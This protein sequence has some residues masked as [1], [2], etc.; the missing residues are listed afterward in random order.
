MPRS[1]RTMLAR[2]MDELGG[3]EAKNLVAHYT[4]V[5]P[6]MRAQQRGEALFNE[7]LDW[8]RLPRLS[9]IFDRLTALCRDAG[10]AYEPS[11]AP[12]L[13]ALYERTYY[14][15]FMPLLYG[16]PADLAYFTRRGHELGLDTLGTIDHYLAAPILHELCHFGRE[17]DALLP[18]HLDEC[19]AGYIGAYVWPELVY[20]E[21]DHD[22]AIYAAPWLSQV[23]Q[24]V[25][26]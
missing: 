12:T 16:Y 15:G 22:D 23:G 6:A 9:A 1:F 13:A 24:A 25:A 11:R 14:G 4:K 19:I 17:R 20:P 10:V 26:R 7:P 8:S 3:D 5:M 21:G 2:A 18:L